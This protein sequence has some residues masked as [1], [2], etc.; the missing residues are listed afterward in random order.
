[1]A[2]WESWRMTRAEL[3]ELLSRYE[4]AVEDDAFNLLRPNAAERALMGDAMIKRRA[5][6]VRAAREANRRF[7]DSIVEDL[8]DLCAGPD[9]PL[10]ARPVCQFHIPGGEAAP[11]LPASSYGS[12]A[13]VFLHL[14]RDWSGLCEH[15]V[16]GTYEPAV[17]QLLKAL[18]PGQN[19]RKPS[20]LVPGCGLGRLALEIAKEG[21]DV[22]AN[23]A[24]RIFLTVAD[25]VLNRPPA[26]AAPLFPL[27]HVFS[28]NFGHAQQYVQVRVPEPRSEDVAMG[29]GSSAKGGGYGAA[30][31]ERAT[32]RMVPGDFAKT[33]AAGRAGHRKFDAI[34]SCFFIDTAENVAELF[35][36]MNELLAE[37]GVWVNVGPLNWRKE[38]R[39]KLTFEEI[40][41]IW[42]QKFGFEFVHQDQL[43]VDYHMPR[44]QKMYTE[45]YN[46]AMTVAIK[47]KKAS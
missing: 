22:E 31:G 36:I 26:E 46:C 23:D 21:Y 37:G 27:A 14:L 3:R 15:V 38:A 42:Q 32:I 6:A 9:V 28:E 45:S 19:G 20:V 30:S 18:P 13:S 17:Q 34:V 2:E 33:Y 7:V 10:P 44:L 5:E 35:T 4:K 41:D 47:R 1:M 39:L 29:G 16:K 12:M 25:W 24:S 40:V 43:D 11:P 8:P